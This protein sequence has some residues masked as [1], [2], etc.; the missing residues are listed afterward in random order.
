MLLCW[1]ND[2]CFIFTKQFIP[3][4]QLISPLLSFFFFIGQ[5]GMRHK[6]WLTCPTLTDDTFL[7]TRNM[8]VPLN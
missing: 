5:I 6:N 8:A 2:P 3:V 1:N 7:Y 4:P